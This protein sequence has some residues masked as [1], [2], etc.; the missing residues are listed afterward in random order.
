MVGSGPCVTENFWKKLYKNKFQKKK[1][2]FQNFFLHISGPALMG[3]HACQAWREYE[4]AV[5]WK[6]FKR[7]RRSF[8]VYASCS[9][10]GFYLI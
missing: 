1:L 8:I 2:D 4:N 6:W 7:R 3:E 5:A 10:T 9:S